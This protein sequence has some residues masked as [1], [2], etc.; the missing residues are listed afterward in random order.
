MLHRWAAS[1]CRHGPH[2]AACSKAVCVRAC[3]R[4]HA[5]RCAAWAAPV[6]ADAASAAEGRR[7]VWLRCSLAAPSLQDPSRAV[8]CNVVSK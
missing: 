1:F 5:R 7:S 2:Y 4:L 8:L 3:G 6:H